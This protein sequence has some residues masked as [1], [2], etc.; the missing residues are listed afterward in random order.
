MPNLTD[1]DKVLRNDTGKDIV[2]K[3]EGIANA[4][5]ATQQ[6]LENLTDVNVTTP[7]DKQAL[8][9]DNATD[10]WVNGHKI[11]AD[12]PSNAVFT[13]TQANWTESN[14]SSPA[15]I[16]NKPQVD[17]T[18]TSGSD[19]L[20]TSGA[21]DTALSGKMDKANPTG[22]GSFSLNRASGSTVGVNS[23]AEGNNCTASGNYSHAEGTFTVASKNGSH[24]EGQQTTASGNYSHA[25]GRDTTASGGYGSHAEGY[26]STASGD[27]SHA[28]GSLTIANHRSQ[29]V[30]GEFNI[31]DTNV[32]SASNRGDYVEIVGNGTSTN[33]SN[34]RTLDWSGN[35]VL[36][37][38]L[39]FNGS[40]SLSGEITR[41][42]NKIDTLPEP[43]VNSF[44]KMLVSNIWA[45]LFFA[46]F[47]RALPDFTILS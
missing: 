5:T 16:Q 47:F 9:Y 45:S 1:A 27:T 31:E 28:E 37:G 23:V 17:T 38:N 24:A 32:A 20:I 7:L 35:E 39:T 41:L 8:V 3:L 15:Y 21:V 26:G 46:C 43:M 14:T 36:A 33:R 4:I 30:F 40:T 2:E 6:S 18:V 22:T 29:H 12:V 34:A 19:N 42:D 11:E 13:D 25:E 10:K 44:G